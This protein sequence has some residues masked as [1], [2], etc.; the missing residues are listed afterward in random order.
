MF[1]IDGETLARAYRKARRAAA[2]ASA[3]LEEFAAQFKH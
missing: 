2:A 3:E 1:E